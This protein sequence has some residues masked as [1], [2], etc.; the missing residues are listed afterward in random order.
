MKKAD[1]ALILPFLCSIFLQLSIGEFPY[2]LFA[3]PCNIICLIGSAI[4]LAI[5]Q[6]KW[7]NSTFCQYVSSVRISV[8]AIGGF[9]LC[10]TVLGVCKQ[11]GDYHALGIHQVQHSWWFIYS[12]SL[13]LIVLYMV[14][15]K[16][17]RR[18][19][20]RFALNHL[21]LL[22][23]LVAGFVGSVDENSFQSV[24]WK[25]QGLQ[26]FIVEYDDHG[27]ALSYEAKIM[28]DGKERSL[29]VNHPLKLNAYTDVYLLDYDTDNKEVQYCVI[30]TV[31]QPWKGA[32]Y[33]GI[34]MMVIGS[35]LL[36]IKGNELSFKN[37]D[38]YLKKG[39]LEIL[40]LVVTI[41][42]AIFLF[43]HLF[44]PYFDYKSMPAILQSWWFVP[45]VAAYMFAYAVLGC[46]TLLCIIELFKGTAIYKQDVKCL[47][48]IGLAFL[49]LGMLFGSLWAK[50]AWGTFWGWDPKETWAVITW[51]IY[52]IYI[53]LSLQ[54]KNN[55]RALYYLLLLGFICIQMCWWGVKLL[56]VAE[57]SAHIYN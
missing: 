19:G 54:G 47:V 42:F 50:K 26:D 4:V 9:A 48:Y 27:Q 38:G 20:L 39:R 56:P 40:L 7:P 36:L 2:E 1:I 51:S 12:L 44:S 25:G 55:T 49:S 22:I 33:L 13:L 28:L 11:N 21:G 17:L 14:I 6:W 16:H 18:G 30:E 10:C 31:T 15:I 43:V 34:I 52:L 29:R 5:I 3:F 8:I 24:L 23:A 46:A 53:H 57:S 37:K 41:L 45:H 32:M 35:A